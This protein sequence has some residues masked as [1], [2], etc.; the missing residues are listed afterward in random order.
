MFFIL[1]QLSNQR[2]YKLLVHTDPVM[3]GFLHGWLE[4]DSPEDLLVDVR[5]LH[6]RHAVNV[7]L[8]SAPNTTTLQLDYVVGLY[9]LSTIAMSSSASSW[10][11]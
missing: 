6:S 4:V 11:I 2:T 8:V 1:Q 5:P 9:T 7:Q 3:F 10:F